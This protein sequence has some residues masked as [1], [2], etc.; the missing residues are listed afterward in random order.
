MGVFF[1]GFGGRGG[2]EGVIF[3]PGSLGF[4]FCP[5]SIIP[6][7]EF[8]STSPGIHLQHKGRALAF[9]SLNFLSFLSLEINYQKRPLFC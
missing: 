4:D 1:F 5:H 7:P 6:S 9:Y 8:R 3:G 2:A